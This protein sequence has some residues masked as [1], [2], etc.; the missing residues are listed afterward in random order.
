YVRWTE[1]RNLESYL[2]LVADNR[3][4]V[5]PLLDRIVSI[6][7]APAVYRELAD[8]KSGLPLGVLIRYDL[9][10]TAAEASA[11]SI[12]LAP[13]RPA[14][15][16]LGY[17]LVGAGSFGTSVL[18]PQ[19]DR[20]RDRFAL[21]AVVSRNAAQGGNFARER[22]VPILSSDLDAVLRDEGIDLVVIA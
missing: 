8:A 3:V 10:D 20:R 15:G 13:P 4:A 11:T 2:Q 6:D 9:A 21:R 18:V 19:M 14:A 16:P 22:Q 12:E 1:N 5:A 7:E 17:A